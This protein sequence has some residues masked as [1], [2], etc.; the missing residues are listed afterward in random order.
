MFV[1]EL[2]SNAWAERMYA[3][4]VV[5]GCHL[6]IAYEVQAVAPTRKYVRIRSCVDGRCLDIIDCFFPQFI[7]NPF[8]QSTL[9]SSRRI[10][11]QLPA[12]MAPIAGSSVPALYCV[13]TPNSELFERTADGIALNIDVLGTAFMLLTRYEERVIS[14]RD[15]HERFPWQASCLSRADWYAR[16]MVD[17]HVDLLFEVMRLLWPSLDRAERRYEFRLSHDV[18]RLF[19]VVGRK[20][21]SVLRAA[22]GD[23]LVRRKPVMAARRL[24]ARMEGSFGLWR[25]EPA[26]T[27]D[28]IME[29]SERCGVRSSFYFI[30][31]R[32][33]QDLD[34]DYILEDARVTGLISSIAARGHEIGL[35]ASYRSFESPVL[36]KTEFDRLRALA[37]RL[38][39]EQEYW[40]GRQHYLRWTVDRSWRA[41]H[42]AGL[43]YDSTVGFAERA[44]F[45]C[46]TCREYPV[47]DLGSRRELPLVE[48][49][50]IAMDVTLLSSEYMGLSHEEALATIVGLAEQCRRY[51]GTFT[52]LWHNTSLMQDADRRLYEAI[53]QRVV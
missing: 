6:G 42:E 19:T 2:P 21:P 9:P 8:E 15:A 27:F 49:P 50:L 44:G 40:G 4:R 1:V 7:A 51:K 28:Y 26:N 13:E 23:I 30:P 12:Q 35:H 31:S 41:W 43:D 25:L 38:K 32:I 3:V 5:L 47:F 24:A 16:P 10:E 33:D 37:A 39:I 52:L 53:L 18:D 46:G 48:R 34:G 36:V 45:R 29:R 11:L 17:E 14:L 20:W 22:A